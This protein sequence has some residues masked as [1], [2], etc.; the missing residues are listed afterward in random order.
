MLPN[1]KDFLAEDVNN[2][3]FNANEFASEMQIDGETVSVV[4]DDDLLQKHNFKADGEGLA[5]GE[6][7]FHVSVS[8]LKEK[9]FI[10]KRIR[11]DSKPYEIINITKDLGVYT[12]TLAGYRS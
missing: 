4:V 10:G 6:L 11:V 2:V 3:F 5:R 7:L 1:F 12:I 9:P 8:S